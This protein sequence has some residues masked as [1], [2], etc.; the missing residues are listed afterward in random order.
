MVRKL[1]ITGPKKMGKSSLI[2]EVIEPK[3]KSIAGFFTQRIFF[4]ND[5]ACAFRLVDISSD[6]KYILEVNNFA[7][8]CGSNIFL[9]RNRHKGIYF[10]DLKIFD[11]FAA[12][13]ISEA[14]LR[15]PALVVLD[16]IGLIEDNARIYIGKIQELLDSNIPVLGVLQLRKGKL[17]SEITG[18]NDVDVIELNRT[19]RGDIKQKIL[20]YIT[21]H[22]PSRGRA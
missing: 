3:R 20:S 14:L 12:K 10:S 1:F 5:E 9:K 16:E 8:N 17:I 4:I 2:K 21:E 15:K 6:E 11:E 22:I 19:N 13:I 7:F 18:R